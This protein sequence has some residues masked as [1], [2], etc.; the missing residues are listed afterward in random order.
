MYSSFRAADAA[1]ESLSKRVDYRVYVCWVE[2]TFYE[3]GDKPDYE[4]SAY[5]FKG[6]YFA[7]D[8]SG[9]Q[10]LAPAD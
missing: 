5:Y 10:P 7:Y 3:L 1:A 2:D 6:E 8:D 9:P 4:G